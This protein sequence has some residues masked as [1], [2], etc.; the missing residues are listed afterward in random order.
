MFC[1]NSTFNINQKEVFIM[2]NT[3]MRFE[4]E[5]ANLAKEKAGILFGNKYADSCYEFAA[6]LRIQ[7]ESKKNSYSNL[8]MICTDALRDIGRKISHKVCFGAVA[9]H[10]REIENTSFTLSAY[11]ERDFNEIPKL[12]KGEDACEW[13]VKSYLSE[14][15]V[16]KAV[17]SVNF[18][19]FAQVI[20][21]CSTNQE[22]AILMQGI[23]TEE[24]AK[25]HR[26]KI[27]YGPD[28][29]KEIIKSPKEI[30]LKN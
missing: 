15:F 24:F 1:I 3:K 19:S 21:I 18:R 20:E 16:N 7:Q 10:Y 12:W 11:G 4:V 17:A 25:R 26:V 27:T 13:E 29:V 14:E 9:K 23:F 8:F 5:D 22:I 30:V 2:E 28:A 6:I